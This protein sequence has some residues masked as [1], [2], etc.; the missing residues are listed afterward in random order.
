MP[1]R[2]K[3]Y[4]E[5]LIESLKDPAEAA[6]YLNAHLEDNEKDSEELFLLALRDVAIAHGVTKVAKKADLGRESLYKTLSK[7]G[8][9]K[10][11]TLRTLLSS[12]GLRLLVEVQRR[13]A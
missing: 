2:T 3:K 9:P 8:N 6:A 1:K 4:E 10:L 7:G 5:S 11:E 12:L 13:H